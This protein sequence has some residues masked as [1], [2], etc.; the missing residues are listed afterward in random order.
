MH[1][2]MLIYMMILKITVCS[3]GFLPQ[4]IIKEKKIE[5]LSTFWRDMKNPVNIK[6]RANTPYDWYQFMHVI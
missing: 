4:V 6:R 5:S 3:S 1:A 2:F